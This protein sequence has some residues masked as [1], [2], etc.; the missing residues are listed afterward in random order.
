MDINL[1]SALAQPLADGP[2]RRDTVSSHRASSSEEPMTAL[3]AARV[4][5][6]RASTIVTRAATCS[7]WAG[8]DGASSSEARERQMRV[9]Q[10]SVSRRNFSTACLCGLD[11]CSLSAPQRE[12]TSRRYP[13]CRFVRAAGWGRGWEGTGERWVEAKERRTGRSVWDKRTWS[14]RARM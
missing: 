5:G 12:D 9:R 6:P 1:S 13:W 3:S 11:F 4:R 8:D 14:R 7:D 2:R 10:G